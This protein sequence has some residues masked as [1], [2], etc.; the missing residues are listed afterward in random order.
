MFDITTAIA[1]KLEH[2]GSFFGIPEIKTREKLSTVEVSWYPQGGLKAA[3]ARVIGDRIL[4]VEIEKVVERI[5]EE[6][7]ENGVDVI[8]K[9]LPGNDF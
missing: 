3:T 1:A 9:Y 6:I 4:S 7:K 5:K 2:E 8:R